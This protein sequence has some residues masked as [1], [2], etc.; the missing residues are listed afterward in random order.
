MYE[1]KLNVNLKLAELYECG[2]Y[3]ETI[4]ECNKILKKDKKK[5]DLRLKTNPNVADKSE[6]SD[7]LNVFRQNRLLRRK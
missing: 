7:F 5:H 3:D 2:K 6:I 4:T 1:E